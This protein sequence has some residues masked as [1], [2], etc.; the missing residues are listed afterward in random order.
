MILET[1]FHS[2]I[3]VRLRR[4]TTTKLGYLEKSMENLLK[5]VNVKLFQGISI[6]GKLTQTIANYLI[7]TIVNRQKTEIF[8]LLLF[9][10]FFFFF[11]EPQS[12]CNSCL[13]IRKRKICMAIK[14]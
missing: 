3:I 4:T 10:F 13:P 12:C 14:S 9:F 7:Q 1:F 5:K 8:L 11:A 2:L 6:S